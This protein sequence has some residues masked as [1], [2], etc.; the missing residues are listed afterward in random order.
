MNPLLLKKIDGQQVI[1]DLERVI[2]IEQL[3]NIEHVRLSIAA[4]NGVLTFTVTET[5]A[6]IIQAIQGGD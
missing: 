1:I 4:G 2:T 3:P 6:D 5:I